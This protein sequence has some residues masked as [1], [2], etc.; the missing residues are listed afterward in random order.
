MPGPPPWKF[1]PTPPL[2]ALSQLGVLYSVIAGQSLHT[3]FFENIFSFALLVLQIE[4]IVMPNSLE[5]FCLF[6]KFFFFFLRIFKYIQ[7]QRD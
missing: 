1:L 6:L 2:P 7:K 3:D 5:F 4:D